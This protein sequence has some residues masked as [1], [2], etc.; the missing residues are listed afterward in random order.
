MAVG[1]DV[2]VMISEVVAVVMAMVSSVHVFGGYSSMRCCVVF[3]GLLE[4]TC[5]IVMCI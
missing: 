1:G 5:D 3:G 2:V 4:V